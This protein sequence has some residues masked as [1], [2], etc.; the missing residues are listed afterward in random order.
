MRL[1][2]STCLSVGVNRIFVTDPLITGLAAHPF[3][4]TCTRRLTSWQFSCRLAVGKWGHGKAGM[5][6]GW[7]GVVMA[8]VA[9]DGGAYLIR[10]HSRGDGQLT[11]VGGA[12]DGGGDYLPG[13]GGHR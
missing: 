8:Q 12:W 10:R 4:L 5:R 1:S 7:D 13:Q 11:A 9:W 2:C 3:A 6:D